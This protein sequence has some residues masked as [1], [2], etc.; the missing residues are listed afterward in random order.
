MADKT[1]IAL[2]DDVR[3]KTLRVLEGVSPEEAAWAPSGLQNTILWHAGHSYVVV[4]WLTLK[5]QGREPEIPSGWFECF[6]WESKPAE[7]PADRWPSLSDVVSQLKAQH[8][9]LH[10]Y[11]AGMSDAELDRPAEGRPEA[12]VRER[13][14]HGLHDEACH[15]GEIMLLRKMLSLKTHR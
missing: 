14:V 13:I 15:S 4:E 9:R 2:L 11:L 7:V 12:T 8:L 5:T 3:G 6:S 10:H 1:L